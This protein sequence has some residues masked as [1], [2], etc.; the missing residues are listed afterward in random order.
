[1]PVGRSNPDFRVFYDDIVWFSSSLRFF[2]CRFILVLS[3]L[4]YYEKGYVQN[5]S[6]FVRCYVMLSFSSFNSCCFKLTIEVFQSRKK[7]PPIQV[8][9]HVCFERGCM[10]DGVSVEVRRPLGSMEQTTECQDWPACTTTHLLQQWR[11]FY[12]GVE[13]HIFGINY[14]ACWHS[15]VKKKESPL[16]GRIQ[17]AQSPRFAQ[18]RIFWMSYLDKNSIFS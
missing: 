7:C 3:Y 4:K 14:F 16:V 18:R 13:I 12:F 2:C 15:H 6:V 1:M 17:Y 10:F 9:I 11:V 8:E 5:N